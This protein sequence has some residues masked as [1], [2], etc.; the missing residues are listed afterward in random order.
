VD[1]DIED[2]VDLIDY[3]RTRI[4]TFITGLPVVEE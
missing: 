2:A 4:E 3:W 1:K